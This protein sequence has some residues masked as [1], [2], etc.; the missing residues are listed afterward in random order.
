M[1]KSRVE[2]MEPGERT[3]PEEGADAP[4]WLVDAML[5]RLARYLRFLG[6]DTEYARGLEDDEIGLRA[7]REG[8]ALLTRDREL[9]TRTPGAFL[10][11]TV[12]ISEQLAEVRRA[13]PGFS[14]QVAFD[15]CPECNASL[16][17][18]GGTPEQGE[19]L[20]IPPRTLADGR[21]IFECRACSRR[22]WDGSHTE[23][24]RAL[25]AD[26]LGGATP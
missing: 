4:H 3:T 5:G 18:W 1:A 6:H 22:F 25:V 7:L 15:R 2:P 12:R 21:P 13:F 17:R 9:A 24:I 8:R 19:A 11:R 20:G 23:R 14:Y 10:L 26:S 16:V